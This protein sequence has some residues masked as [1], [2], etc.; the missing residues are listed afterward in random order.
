MWD[1]NCRRFCYR[2]S[3]RETRRGGRLIGRIVN[4]VCDPFQ[5][6]LMLCQQRRMLPSSSLRNIELCVLQLIII[7]YIY[8]KLPNLKVHVT[9]LESHCANFHERHDNFTSNI[10]FLCRRVYVCYKSYIMFVFYML[11]FLLFESLSP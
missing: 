7:L 9:L 10:I 11:S 6:I 5:Q 1:F 4:M 2:R 8:N 3:C